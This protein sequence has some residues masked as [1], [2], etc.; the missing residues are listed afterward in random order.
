MIMHKT[1]VLICISLITFQAS[2]AQN[3]NTYEG[4][5]KWNNTLEGNAEYQFI[6]DRDGKEIPDGK[7]RF[8]H[9]YRDSTDQSILNKL[10]VNG[11]YKSGKKNGKWAYETEEHRVF[12]DDIVDFKII[13]DLK[14]TVSSLEASYKE[15]VADGAWEYLVNN[16]YEDKI[17][18]I[19]RLKEAKFQN[20]HI[21]G[22]FSYHYLF[23]YQ[24][25]NVRGLLDEDGFMDGEW[26]LQY[27]DDQKI[28]EELRIYQN[29]FLLSIEARSLTD[30]QILRN[31]EFEDVKQRL[32]MLTNGD[33]R[34]FTI[35][36][37]S[38]GIFF[39]NGYRTSF[40]EYILQVKGND[41]I[42]N[43]LKTLLQ[44]DAE[45]YLKDGELI[46]FPLKTRR[47]KYELPND[48]EKLSAQANDVFGRLQQ[49]VSE[50]ADWNALKL[51]KAKSDSLSFAHEFF[52]GLYLK[53]DDLEDIKNQLIAQNAQFLDEKV[54]MRQELGFK[55]DR[56]TIEYVFDGQKKYKIIDRSTLYREGDRLIVSL[57]NYLLFEEDMVNKFIKYVED[58][59]QMI[60]LGQNVENL[61][62]RISDKQTEVLTLYNKANTIN[63]LHKSLLEHLSQKFLE[64]KYDEFSTTYARA[65]NYDQKLESG[66]R[67]MD[68][69]SELEK[70]LPGI[71]NVFQEAEY[72]DDLYQENVFNPF[73]YSS[74][75]QRA[76]DRLYRAGA[77][78]LFSHYLQLLEEEDDYTALKMHVD[79]INK[80]HNRLRELREEDTRKI[81][82]RLRRN[83]TIPSIES[84]LE[85]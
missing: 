48:Y 15:G 60:E 2:I 53:F 23:N 38:F 62:T 50:R 85:L 81:E 68:L 36:N 72:I 76:K 47:F 27:Y 70:I 14:S 71:N 63:S 57:V 82:R 78:R 8:Q 54:F 73:T 26:I 42:N 1:L 10:L 58:E 19:A 75:D 66:K 24:E 51:N 25:L 84:A 31:L 6:K 55:K 35:S 59:L 34:D 74:Y 20:G 33:N 3:R 69:M 11:N 13:A 41:L 16:H 28:I 46:E 17:E 39:N 7:F 61:E 79:K 80:L 44:Y 77:E 67:L 5:F 64:E 43:F 32:D 56:D 22:D 12:I 18:S 29:G 30:N 4:P 45:K 65:E 52:R 9:K 37:E 49:K 83:N 40:P 21:T